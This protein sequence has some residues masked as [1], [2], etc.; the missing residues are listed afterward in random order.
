MNTAQMH[1]LHVIDVDDRGFVDKT[2]DYLSERPLGVGIG[3]IA[4]ASLAG[5]GG[6]LTVTLW[7]IGGALGVLLSIWMGT[8]TLLV[9]TL[10]VSGLINFFL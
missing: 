6:I 2:L 5:V 3:A 10:A 9:A 4:N 8:A 1:H 7:G